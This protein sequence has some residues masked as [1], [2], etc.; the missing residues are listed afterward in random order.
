MTFPAGTVDEAPLYELGKSPAAVM[1]FVAA[2]NV[3]PTTFG[4]VTPAGPDETTRFTADPNATEVPAAGDSDM[5]L[6]AA[7][8]AEDCG[9]TVP[10]TRPVAVMA[11]VAAACVRP[12]TFGT[13]TSAGPDETTRF[14]GEPGATEAPAA[15]DWDMTLPGGTVDEGWVVTVPGMSPA[16]VM[17]LVAAACS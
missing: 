15:G 10:A 4:T 17:A 12:T 13:A 9:V 2:D 7:T 6:P 5:T 14:T 16:A 11:E 3:R 8:V 1:A